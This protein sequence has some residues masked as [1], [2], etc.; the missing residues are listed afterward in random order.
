MK[1]EIN[2]K[3][4]YGKYRALCSIP[5]PHRHTNTKHM[6]TEQYILL[7]SVDH[8]RNKGKNKKIPRVKWKWKHNLPEPLGHSKG[9]AKRKICSYECLH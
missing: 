5:V 3:W 2:S 1:L 8:P 9:S 4:K 7:W 6:K